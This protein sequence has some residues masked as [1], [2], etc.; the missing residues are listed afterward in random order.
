MSLIVATNITKDYQTGDVTVRALKG[1]SF[2]IEPA[3]FVSFVGPSGSGKTTLLN[4]IGCLDKPTD[5]KLM[6]AATEVLHLDR[7]Q[8]ASFRGSNIG[9]I[10]QDFNLIPVLTVYENIEYPLLMVQ[11][12][13]TAERNQRVNALLTAVG[14]TD[15]KDKF[16]D[17]ISGGQKQRVAVARALVTNPK[18]VLAD[19]PTAN[20]D[21]K[22]AYMVIELM[23]KM[24]D[25]FGT[26]FIFSTHDQKIVGEAEII[27][28][29]EDGELK[30]KENKGGGG[31]G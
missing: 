10:F 29:I 2:E 5:G 17:Q 31:N 19:E 21:H 20:L 3:S 22:T 24:R 9:F 27:F 4:L 12:M 26:T 13:P 18:L 7:K 25:E 11:N 23:R 30:G 28:T 6:V 1:L 16:P 8:S 14:M 15:Q